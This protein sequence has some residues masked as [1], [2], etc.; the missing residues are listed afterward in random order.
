MLDSGCLVLG[1]G[2]LVLGSG[3][4][5]LGSGCLVLGSGCRPALS[6]VPGTHGRPL[7]VLMVAHLTSSLAIKNNTLTYNNYAKEHYQKKTLA[8]M[9]ASYY[10]N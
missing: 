7:D 10:S 1:S 6:E 4:L 5:V 2:C 3:C 8:S 9:Q